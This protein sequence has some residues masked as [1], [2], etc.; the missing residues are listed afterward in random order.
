MLCPSNIYR[1]LVGAG[2]GIF[3]ISFFVKINFVNFYAFHEG[4]WLPSCSIYTFGCFGKDI[5]LNVVFKNIRFFERGFFD[6]YV[7]VL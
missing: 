2:R 6:Q 1:L 7:A 4:I 5:G 3:R